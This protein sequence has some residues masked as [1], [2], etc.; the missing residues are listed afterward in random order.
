MDIPTPD[1]AYRLL[2]VLAHPDDE[3]FGM[4]GTLALYAS[5]GVEVHL[6]CATRGEVGD[7]DPS[8]LQGFRSIEE[9]RES[10][11]CCAADELHLAGVHFL[12]YRD[13]GMPGSP[14][15][16]HPNALAA[17]PVEVVAVRVA[18]YIR[19]L[20]PQVVVTFDPL[21]GYKH[22]DH[23]AIH[24]ATVRA[25]HL[26]GD[27]DFHSN[28]PPYSPQKLYFQVYPKKLAR[29]LVRLMPLVGRNPRRF[30]RNKDIDLVDLMQD[31]DFPV[32]AQIDISSV[33]ERREAA[34]ACHASQLPG[35]PPR[36]GLLRALT[37]RLGGKELFMRAYPPVENGR[38]ERDLFKDV[39]LPE[40]VSQNLPLGVRT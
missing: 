13:S 17:T 4:G 12:G 14:D 18:D 25:F 8:L 28:Y 7:V 36:S 15:N 39:I 22:P 11:L 33:L 27:P 16:Q 2:A 37:G 3:T 32:H 23:I 19:K 20:K 6:V 5:R 21:G 34:M 24:K 1:N 31:S 9:R 10:E 38:R 30:G 40:G 35:G 29:F 26:A